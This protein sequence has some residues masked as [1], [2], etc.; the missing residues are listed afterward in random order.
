MVKV[1]NLPP[2]VVVDENNVK[3]FQ[4]LLTKM[5]RDYCQK[6]LNF[7]DLFCSRQIRLVGL[8]NSGVIT[9]GKVM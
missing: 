3:T 2:Q 9:A 8:N 6:G 5:A 7:Q 4:R 1:Y